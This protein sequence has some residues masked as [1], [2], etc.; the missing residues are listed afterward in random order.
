MI[1]PSAWCRVRP[2]PS[3]ARRLR[4]WLTGQSFRAVLPQASPARSTVIRDATG[5]ALDQWRAQGHAKAAPTGQAITA[6]HPAQSLDVAVTLT[7][8]PRLR[9]GNLQPEGQQAVRPE[10]IVEIA[11]L[12][13]GEVFDPEDVDRATQRLR[14]TGTF[15]V[16]CAAR[17]RGHKP[18]RRARH[19]CRRGGSAPAPHRSRV[20]IRHRARRQAKWVL[21]ASEPAGRGRAFPN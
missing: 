19:F 21:A 10:R 17:G 18:G 16:G 14:A 12:P 3:A 8:G 7:P 9:F 15:F 13:T 20:G 2:L 4:L 6:N 11:G 1:S 5:T